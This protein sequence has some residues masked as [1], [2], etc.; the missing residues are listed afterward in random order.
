M[1]SKKEQKSGAKYLKPIDIGKFIVKQKELLKM[2]EDADIEEFE[3]MREGLSKKE[4][5][6]MGN[7]MGYLG[8]KTWVFRYKNL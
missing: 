5:A 6:K 2:E 4:M 7:S 1:E 3:M 8:L